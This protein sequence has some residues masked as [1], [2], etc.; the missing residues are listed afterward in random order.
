MTAT[1]LD[2]GHHVCE[3]PN[4]E[5][6]G[7]GARVQCDTCRRVYWRSTKFG[8]LKAYWDLGGW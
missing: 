3:L 4:P 5:P 8:S 2:D 6:F 7:A 1:V